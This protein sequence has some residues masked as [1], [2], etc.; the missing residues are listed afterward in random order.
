[1]A[2]RLGSALALVSLLCLA[3]ATSASAGDD[4]NAQ[5]AVDAGEVAAERAARPATTSPR[6]APSTACPDQDTLAAPA[7]LQ[8]EAMLCMTNFARASA[9][10]DPLLAAAELQQSSRD[11][12]ADV[13]GC[14]EFSHFACGREFTYWIRAAGYIGESC[15][16]AGENL[17]WGTGTDGSVRAIFRAWM[18]SPAHRRNILGDYDQVGIGRLSGNLEGHAGARVWAAHFGSRCTV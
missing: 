2:R 8:E 5:R 7:E 1:M 14:D 9:G 18:A 12:A 16:H 6:I 15:W 17:A 13:L 11:K 10:L 3:L 4:L